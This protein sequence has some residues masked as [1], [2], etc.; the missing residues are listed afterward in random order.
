MDDKISPESSMV[1]GVSSQPA[2]ETVETTTTSKEHVPGPDVGNEPPS[3]A[4]SQLHT[5]IRRQIARPRD[6]SGVKVSKRPSRFA[7][8]PIE[9]GFAGWGK[10][11]W[12]A[13]SHDELA[14]A[15]AKLRDADEKVLGQWVG[16]A[17]VGNDLLG[18][19]FY[20]F[21][22]VAVVAG[23]YSPISLFV[24]TCILFIFRPIMVELA[25]AIPVSGSNYMYLLNSTKRFAALAAATV[26]LLDN[27]ATAVV[28]AAASTV[29]IEG[30]VDLPFSPI[31][32]TILLLILF[33]IV[34]VAGL[35]ESASLAFVILALHIATMLALM[36]SSAVSWGVHGNAILRH[37][38]AIA[39]APDTAGA[40]KSIFYGVCLSFLGMTG[41]ECAPDYISS[42][43]RGRY[44]LVLRNLLWPAVF[45]NSTLM[46]LAFASLPFSE[47]AGSPNILSQLGYVVAGRW[48]RIWVTVDACVCLCAGI[49]TGIISNI[50]LFE[51]LT[52]DR[53]L[54]KFVMHPLPRSGAQWVSILAF[55]IICCILY[56]TT[57][58]KLQIVSLMFTT[59]FLAIVGLFA[60][61]FLMINFHRSRLPRTPRTSVWLGFFALLLTLVMLGGNVALDPRTIAY[62]AAYFAVLFAILCLFANPV[63]PLQW[64]YWMLDQVSV[65]HR[66][67]GL[68]QRIVLAIT[69]FRRKP[70]A[71]LIKTDQVDELLEMILY[72][73]DNEPT[74]CVKLIHFYESSIDAIPSELEANM[75]IIDEAFP[76]IT[77]DLLFVQA[78]FTPNAIEALSE[79]IHV[80][81]N[82]MFMNSFSDSFPYGLD[83]MGT[84]IIGL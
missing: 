18:S 59:A 77:V 13:L 3:F 19:V 54:P 41:F 58:G 16:A 76:H 37:N 39:R 64:A 9:L 65:L 80:P 40:L 48:L 1:A 12:T 63:T 56:L 26:K 83:E 7:N 22:A 60:L 75:H 72:V 53:V 5:I 43:K 79:K 14:A 74:S 78:P 84:R 29:Y 25:S 69:R 81:R 51:R 31:W 11:Q 67:T 15:E 28:S 32:L 47:I 50:A 62:F 71:C 2:H 20:A 33:S 45:L 30:E 49:L 8:L 17:V 23:I 57:G 70:V 35:K 42:M 68:A 61:S 34:A 66:R 6:G 10:V 82:M 44:P 46:L 21:P 27:V 73:Q 52:K 36:I 55:L 4:Q 24:A 38:W